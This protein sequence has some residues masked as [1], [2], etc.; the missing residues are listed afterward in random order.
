MTTVKRGGARQSRLSSLSEWLSQPNAQDRFRDRL[1]IIII[2]G[3][4]FFFGGRGDPCDLPY[5]VLSWEDIFC[6]CTCM[7]LV[8][9]NIMFDLQ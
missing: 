6:L 1:K 8:I 9:F 2:E 7:Y 4:V 5:Q 3:G